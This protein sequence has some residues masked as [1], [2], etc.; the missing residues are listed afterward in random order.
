MTE[1]RRRLPR[2]PA[3]VRTTFNIAAVGRYPR[4]NQDRVRVS[5][6]ASAF[7]TSRLDLGTVVGPA[8]PVTDGRALDA[9]PAIM[10]A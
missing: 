1:P 3:A 9:K 4:R 8:R 6:P 5:S 7:S 10:M 2:R